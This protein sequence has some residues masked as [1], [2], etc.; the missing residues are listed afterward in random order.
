MT[1]R[2]WYY[3]HGGQQKGPI[4]TAQLKQLAANGQLQLADLVWTDQMENWAAASTV[5]GLFSSEGVAAT[6]GGPPLADTLPGSQHADS[7]TGAYAQQFS[8]ATQVA[9][10]ASREAA[11]ALTTL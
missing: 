8:S 6:A 11:G 3:S 7:P 10:A 1:D 9:G 2:M 4:N 5:K